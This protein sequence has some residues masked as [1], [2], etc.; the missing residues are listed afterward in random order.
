M[1]GEPW[2]VFLFLCGVGRTAMLLFRRLHLE[3]L[4]GSHVSA[5]RHAPA[6]G[7]GEEADPPAD[8]AVEGVKPN[9]KAKAKGKTKPEAQVEGTAPDAVLNLKNLL[10]DARKKAGTPAADDAPADTES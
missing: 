3:L 5:V 9:A 6:I 8:I 10:A 4:E 1:G 7:E 2:V